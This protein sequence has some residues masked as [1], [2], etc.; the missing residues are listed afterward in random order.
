VVAGGTP[1]IGRAACATGI[2][3]GTGTGFSVGGTCF[4]RCA[5]AV[6][7]TDADGYG[8]ESG[9]TC[10][11][12]GSVPAT[13]GVPCQPTALPPPM[14]DGFNIGGTCFARCANATTDTDGDGYGYENSRTCVV[15][16]SVPATM[17]VAC[18]PADLPPPPPPPPGTGWVS[19]YTATVF[20][21]VDCAKFGFSDPTNL[22]QSACVGRGAVSLNTMNQ[23]YYGAPGDLSTLWTGPQCTCTNGGQTGTRCNNPPNCSGQSDCAKCVEVACNA[24]GTFSYMANGNTNDMYCKAG[25]SVVVQIIDACPHNHPMNT[26]WCT[27]ARPD[28]IDISCSAF[29][30]ITQGMQPGTVGY[31]NAYVRPVDCSVGLGPKTY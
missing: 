2:I 1:T 6:T 11:V 5:S 19:T 8:Y 15:A 17:G 25:T 3:R 23:T 27:T 21:Q 26:Y 24:T 4:P 18:V 10:I 7:D 29:A 9:A 12:A 13:M 22:N 30:S 28:H 20:G 16:G 14:G 31:V